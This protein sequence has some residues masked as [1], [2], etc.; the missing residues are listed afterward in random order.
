MIKKK[1]DDKTEQKLSYIGDYSLPSFKKI[2]WK[3][4]IL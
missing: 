1:R 2:E 3:R 4:P